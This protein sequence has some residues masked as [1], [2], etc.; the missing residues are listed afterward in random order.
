MKKLNTF[1]YAVVLLT[2]LVG[3]VFAA[4]SYTL[5]IGYEKFDAKY[6][7]PLSCVQIDIENM[8]NIFALNGYKVACHEPGKILDPNTL[9]PIELNKQINVNANST[10]E[11]ELLKISIKNFLKSLPRNETKRVV[12]Y[13]STHGI[14]S[15][16]GYYCAVKDMEVS[17]KSEEKDG[18]EIYDY[19]KGGLS[20]NWLFN[21]IKETPYDVILILDTCH[22]GT[23]N[24]PDI[25]KY[26]SKND[27]KSANNRVIVLARCHRMQEAAATPEYSKWIA[28]GLRGFADIKEKYGEVGVDEL[29]S[30]LLER[31]PKNTNEK[32]IVSSSPMKFVLGAAQDHNTILTSII[33]YSQEELIQMFAMEIDLELQ[34]L[35]YEFNQ[36]ESKK[37][38]NVYVYEFQPALPKEIQNGDFETTRK[39]LGRALSAALESYAKKSGDYRIVSLEEIQEKTQPKDKDKDKD[40]GKG[41][42][43]AEIEKLTSLNDSPLVFICGTVGL[44]NKEEAKKF[45]D[46]IETI[47]KY[48]NDNSF[49]HIKCSIRC[50]G[51]QYPLAQSGGLMN[52]VVQN[53][54]DFVESNPVSIAP[55]LIQGR[56]ENEPPILSAIKIDKIAAGLNKPENSEVDLLNTPLNNPLLKPVIM[57]KKGGS[58]AMKENPSLEEFSEYI[59]SCYQERKISINNKNELRVDLKPEEEF[60]IVLDISCPKQFELPEKEENKPYLYTRVLIDGRNTIASELPKDEDISSEFRTVESLKKA[61]PWYIGYDEEWSKT[62]TNTN[63]NTKTGS[64]F[65][66]PGFT[67]KNERYPRAFKMTDQVVRDR[68]GKT[69]SDYTGLI[70][71]VAYT[72]IKPT[73]TAAV[74]KPG[75]PIPYKVKS[76]KTDYIPGPMVGVWVIQ[77]GEDLK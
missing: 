71:I 77:Y 15:K 16:D 39:H 4:D 51:K 2:L 19:F 8:R 10:R 47:R 13:L 60:I 36:N 49:L 31:F 21:E 12:I 54:D 29:H 14:I 37:T 73:V 32:G 41:I 53:L 18:I 55:R 23:G 17:E 52:Y 24:I 3:Q 20:Y 75:D 42:T 62:E 57:V 61:E 1:F 6:I 65:V 46:G 40:K 9:Q 66:I 59:N 44:F 58:P 38:T 27:N 76:V 72:P 11:T 43:R 70:Q 5:L 74:V 35:K 69:L 48:G 45:G 68:E 28:Q 22:S 34:K 26:I 67:L 56:D 33:P 7:S 25:S 30:F 63:T 64:R 50:R